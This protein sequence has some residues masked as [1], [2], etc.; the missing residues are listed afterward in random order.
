[1]SVP[2]PGSVVQGRTERFTIAPVP[3]AGPLVGTVTP[4][5]RDD[6]PATGH[7]ERT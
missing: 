1:M 4:V 7:A 6:D 5:T 3:L 2:R